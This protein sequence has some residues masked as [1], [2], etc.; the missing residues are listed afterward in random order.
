MLQQDLEADLQTFIVQASAFYY[1]SV[2]VPVQLASF[3]KCVVRNYALASPKNEVSEKR[4]EKITVRNSHTA[5]VSGV[6]QTLLQ[7]YLS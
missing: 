4:G 3:Q 5:E 1:S 7:Q 6:S 2:C